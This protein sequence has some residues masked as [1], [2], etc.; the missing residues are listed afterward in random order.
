MNLTTEDKDKLF[1][2]LDHI[3]TR[4]E[5]VERGMYGD[6]DN[7]YNGVIKDMGEIKRFKA[8]MTKVGAGLSTFI[9]IAIST[10]AAIFKHS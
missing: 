9:S 3:E 5:K 1:S 7:G 8:T 4:I 2:K 10:I 6:P